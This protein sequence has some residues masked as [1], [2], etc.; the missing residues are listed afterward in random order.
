MQK[1]LLTS[2]TEFQVAVWCYL[3][4]KPVMCY[5]DFKV[6]AMFNKPFKKWMTKQF[7]WTNL[8]LTLNQ[9]IINTRW[10]AILKRILKA[11]M[12]T[13]TK[14]TPPSKCRLTTT[15][16]HW[17]HNRNNLFQKGHSPYVKP[18]TG[19]RAN[20]SFLMMAKVLYHDSSVHHKTCILRTPISA[21]CP[22]CRHSRMMRC[23]RGACL[24]DLKNLEIFR[25]ACNTMRWYSR[26][27]VNKRRS[28][29]SKMSSTCT[30]RSHTLQ[31]PRRSSSWNCQ[32]LRTW[33]QTS[34]EGMKID[35]PLFGL[36]LV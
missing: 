28:K 6:K 17:T 19:Q 14:Q 35:H 12:Q 11:T 31:L 21:P 27:W 33:I 34:I 5:L 25:E 22:I 20:C 3:I 2:T 7:S 18:F 8:L 4:R 36:L 26:R 10:W 29:S 13:R 1:I 16:T 15:C 32:C 9:C 23:T 30:T 24:Q